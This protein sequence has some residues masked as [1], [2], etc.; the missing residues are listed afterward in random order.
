MTGVQ[1]CALP[2]LGA[3][4]AGTLSFTRGA[5]SATLALTG[6]ETNSAL[7]AALTASLETL[8]GV[9][10]VQVSGNRVA[11]YEIEFI[12][13]LAGTDVSDLNVA[14]GAPE[15]NATVSTTLAAQAGVDEIKQ[16]SIER[17]RGTPLPV[18]VSVIQ[19]SAYIYIAPVVVPYVQN[20]VT[21]NARYIDRK[22]TRLN[23]SHIPLSRMPSSA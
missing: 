8:V 5:D 6:S 14:L 16:I 10:N 15:L 23:S 4:A 2:I 9:G 21:N 11:G 1:T 17:L 22:S 18:Q 13:E 7:I 3:G 12:G 20:D 19:V